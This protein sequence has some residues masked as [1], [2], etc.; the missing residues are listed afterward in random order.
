MEAEGHYTMEAWTC[1][2]QTLLSEFRRGDFR[3]LCQD[4]KAARWLLVPYIVLSLVL[5]G[6]EFW[7]GGKRDKA[8]A[9]KE[10]GAGDLGGAGAS[11][12]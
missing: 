1:Q 6:L 10:G 4:G 9:K 7:V 11:D 2:T 3:Q 12:E 8:N 5:L